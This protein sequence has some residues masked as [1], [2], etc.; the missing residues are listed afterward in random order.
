VR[1]KGATDEKPKKAKTRKEN[2]IMNNIKRI[3][4][5]TAIS[6]TVALASSA[7]EAERIPFNGT[8]VA[9]EDSTFF[10]DPENA[11]GFFTMCNRQGTLASAELGQF[12][13]YLTALVDLTTGTVPGM[14]S[15]RL[16]AA[17]GDSIFAYE[18]GTA[19]VD[20][21]YGHITEMYTITRGTGR[22]ANAIGSFTVHRTIDLTTGDST[23]TFNG[24]IIVRGH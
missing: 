15:A 10:P 22:Y 18:G 1:N 24:A 2:K 23:G 13:L 14:G 21:P 3:S 6:L 9:H 8:W 7:V 16:V 11:I 5:M 4:L 17:N 19:V 12:T 20:F